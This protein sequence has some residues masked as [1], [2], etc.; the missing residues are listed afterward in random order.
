MKYYDDIYKDKDKKY[1]NRFK[2]IAKGKRKPSP[3]DV[4]YIANILSITEKEVR[5]REYEIY[6]MDIDALLR[7]K[8]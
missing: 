1:Y 6:H 8:E 5:E 3:K 2:K 4:I 7:E